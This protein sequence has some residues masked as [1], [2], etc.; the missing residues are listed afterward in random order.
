M[1]R[2]ALHRQVAADLAQREMMH[3]LMHAL[4]G[5]GRHGTYGDGG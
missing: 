1:I 2:I 5:T 4:A 3:E